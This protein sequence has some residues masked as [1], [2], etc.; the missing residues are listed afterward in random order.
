MSEN[1]ETTLSKPPEFTGRLVASRP[2]WRQLGLLGNPAVFFDR[3]IGKYGD[4][5]KYR[6]VVGFHLVNHPALVRQVLRETH[7]QFDKDSAI[8]RRFK[9]AFGDGLVTAEGERWKKRRKL[10]QP[11]FKSSAIRHFFDLMLNAATATADKWA[12]RCSK[13]E[14]FDVADEMD[15]LA[16]T[17]AGRSFFGQAFDDGSEDI[18]RWT[19]VINRYCAL[20]PLSIISNP[21]V[22]TPMNLRLRGVMG[23]YDQFLGTL[24]RERTDG[25]WKNDLLGILLTTEDEETG[26]VMNPAE[27]AEEVLGMLIGGHETTAKALTWIWHEL[28]RHPEVEEKIYQEIQ[29]V[30]GGGPVEF[31]HLG[32]F[33]FT[34]MV[35][36]ETMRLHPP[37]WFE[38]RNAR[39]DVELGGATIPKGSMVVFSRYSLQRHPAFWKAPDEFNPERFNP[40]NPENETTNFAN[41]PFGGGPRICIGRHFS[42]M[43]MRIVVATLLQRYRVV[44][45]SSDRHSMVAKMTMAPKYGVRVRL[46]RR[47][48]V[49][50]NQLE[51]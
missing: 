22:P 20:P 6:G 49:H 43:E 35:I 25:E 36:Q 1:T 41:V 38:N 37:F 12:E 50:E 51:S 10:L 48:S 33:K 9:N 2:F 3:L 27:L 16:L 21:K 46:E 18:R 31:E 30:T 19:D 29:T 11:V 44:V 45:D 13:G 14:V 4:F 39:C 26:E 32:E 28:H 15:H 42:M 23:E 47:E 34:D 8:Y 24:I 40:D 5:V 7:R 17:V